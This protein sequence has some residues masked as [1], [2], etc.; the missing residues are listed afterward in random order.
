[1]AEKIK[2]G[3]FV[4]KPGRTPS[5]EAQDLINQLIQPDAAKRLALDQCRSHSWV[6]RW[7]S[8]SALN[9]SSGSSDAIDEETIVLPDDPQDVKAF[10]SSLTNFTSKWR[11]SAN[12]RG[13]GKLVVIWQIAA[14][15]GVTPKTQPNIAHARAE[16]RTMLQEYFPGFQLPPRDDVADPEPGALE[17]GYPTLPQNSTKANA[18]GMHAAVGAPLAPVKEESAPRI[19]AS[20]KIKLRVQ[21]A[22]AGLMLVEE[23]GGMRVLEVHDCPGQPGLQA[24]D[25]IVETNGERLGPT[26]LE[27]E[28]TFRRNFRDGVWIKINRGE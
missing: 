13:R 21:D 7:L 4:F 8:S 24:Q 10:R 22:S 6:Q 9:G 17:F 1:M 12:L 16:L 26:P 28:R 27:V 3:N 2:K 14:S 11:F 20:K 25:L 23:S 5:E 15:S 18:M 19:G